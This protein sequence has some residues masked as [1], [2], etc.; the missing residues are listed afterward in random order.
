MTNITYTLIWIC[1]TGRQHQLKHRVSRPRPAPLEGSIIK[2]ICRTTYITGLIADPLT[3]PASNGMDIVSA[4]ILGCVQGLTEFLPVSS[5]G[6]L[7]LAH[8][9]LRVEETNSLAFDAVLHLATATAVI[10]YF[11][12]EIFVLVQALL[13]K[14]GRL[15]VNEKDM[16]IIK[17]LAVGTIPAVILGILLESYMDNLFRSPVLVALVLIIGSIF[18]MYAEYRYQNSFHGRDVDT[19]M[20][21]KIGL[22]QAL[23]LIPGMSRSGVTIAG[24]MLL[25]IPRSDATRFAFLLAVPV[26]LGAGAKKILELITSS[27]AVEWVPVGVGAIASFVVGLFAIHFM[28]SFVKRHTLWPFIWYRIILAGFIIF[29]TYFG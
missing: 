8:A 1:S 27:V 26:I 2:T 14:L 13:R 11:F 23:A 6:H 12:D 22:F 21:F 10:V 17:A 28:I 4:V 24:G 20:G 16:V 29:V 7:I 19:A 9:V 25:G 18:F 3:G 5:T 15:P